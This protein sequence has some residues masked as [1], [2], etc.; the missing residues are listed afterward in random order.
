[1]IEGLFLSLERGAAQQACRHLDLLA[2]QGVCGDRHAGRADWPGQN[3]TLVEAE[4]IEAFCQLSA[5]PFDLSLTR[6]NVVTRGIRLNPLLGQRF[7][8]GTCEFIGVELCEPC[9]TLGKRL[10]NE[11]LSGPEVVKH[12]LG[13]GGLRVDVLV[14]GRIALGDSLIVIDSAGADR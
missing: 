11:H 1:M 2:G 13:R 5:H 3:L 4:E 9:R 14:G 8:I 7:R 10:E 12:W 6:R